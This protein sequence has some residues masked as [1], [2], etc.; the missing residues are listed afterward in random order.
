MTPQIFQEI[1]NNALDSHTKGQLPLQPYP[2]S[3]KK[4][5]MLGNARLVL[6]PTKQCNEWAV[7]WQLLVNG[8][9]EAMGP[10]WATIHFTPVDFRYT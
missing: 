6:A 7:S 4:M 3:S 8:K 9:V 10:G 2:F 1:L 5:F